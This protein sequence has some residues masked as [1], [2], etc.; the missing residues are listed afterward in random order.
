M[1]I[2][3]S[4][5][6]RATIGFNDTA[7]T[8]AWRLG[9]A[10]PLHIALR[11]PLSWITVYENVW[12]WKES[13]QQTHEQTATNRRSK[14]LALGATADLQLGCRQSFQEQIAA[15]ENILVAST[16]SR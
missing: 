2:R 10:V 4:C 12:G 5:A 6:T 8:G 14:T 1:V 11:P 3:R 7:R 16:Q 13:R 9:A 15:S